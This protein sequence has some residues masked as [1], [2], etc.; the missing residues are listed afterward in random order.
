MSYGQGVT[1]HQLLSWAK[2]TQ[3]GEINLLAIRSEQV[4]EK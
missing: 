2:Q 3:L 1:I 4:N